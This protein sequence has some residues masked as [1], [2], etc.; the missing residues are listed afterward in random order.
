MVL[1]EADTFSAD[2]A[3]SS[4][5]DPYYGDRNP[6]ELPTRN[7][8][9]FTVNS[10]EDTV[11]V[12]ISQLPKLFLQSEPLPSN[13][14]SSIKSSIQNAG[15]ALGRPVTQDEADALAFHHAKAYRI[16]S[17]GHPVGTVI[18]SA[19]AF[20][21]WSKFG[22]PGWT[23]G[24]KFNPQRFGFLSGRSARIAW[25]SARLLAYSTVGAFLG[26][27]LAGSYALTVY[28]VGRERDPRLKEVGLAL[29]KHAA[30]GNWPGS[31]KADDSPGRKESAGETFDMARQRQRAQEAWREHRAGQQ[32]P[33]ER[34]NVMRAE[35]RADDMS[36]TGGAF[37]AEFVDPGSADVSDTAMMSDDQARRQSESIQRQQEADYAKSQ[38]SRAAHPS[39]QRQGPSRDAFGM[40]EDS[41]SVQSGSAWERLRQKAQSGGST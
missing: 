33:T 20:R 35:S 41:K 8:S 26:G 3:P 22:F 2:T 1:E 12:N 11:Y 32:Q 31:R 15:L 27:T 18:A 25:H 30:N 6:T 40:Q 13:M 19:L 16:G 24:E 10:G 38:E 34:R 9:Y 21:S 23:P 17:Y 37:G 5:A 14:L 29:R 28:G 39:Q 7:S 36:P 4:D